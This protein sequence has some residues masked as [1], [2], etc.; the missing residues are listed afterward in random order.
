MKPEEKQDL[1][2]K[3]ALEIVNRH[4]SGE[5]HSVTFDQALQLILIEQIWR[6]GSSFYQV[7]ESIDEL[8]EVFAED[9]ADSLQLMHNR[10]NEIDHTLFDTLGS[11]KTGAALDAVTQ[12]A[13]TLSEY[14]TE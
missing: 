10:L 8:R 4:S 7:V 3:S 6:V 12:I 11:S 5:E 1:I 14:V 2:Y 13:D 9:V